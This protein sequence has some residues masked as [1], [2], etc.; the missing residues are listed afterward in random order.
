MR[1]ENF[2]EKYFE[3]LSRIE[4]LTKITD[5]F[6]IRYVFPNSHGKYWFYRL[7]IEEG[8]DITFT[9]LPNRLNYAFQIVN[10]DEEVL[11][12]GVCT[13]GKMEIL[14]YPSLERYSYQQGQACLYYSKNSVEKFEFYAKYY[15]GFSI[16]LHLDYFE[17]FFKLGKSSW[18]EKEWR[19]NLKNM[20]QEKFLKIWNSSIFLQ[21]LAKEIADFKIK[22]ILDYFEFKGKINYFLVKLMLECMG[23]SDSEDEKI[24][25]LTF[26]IAQDYE[27]IYSLQEISRF[28]DTPI[29]QLQKMMKKKKGITICQY[30]RNLKLEYAKILLEKNDYTVAEVASMIGYSNPSKF[31]KIFFERYQKKPKKF[32]NNKIY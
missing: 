24:Q 27:K 26:L 25:H 8:M 4:N 10:W 6:G 7:A 15:K 30:I 23:I 21:A 11:E 20:L 22:S 28:L 3:R 18:L 29:Y 32:K 2:I 14:C 17:Y 31:S 1:K 13:E 16:H 5:L 9:S 12:F 19:N